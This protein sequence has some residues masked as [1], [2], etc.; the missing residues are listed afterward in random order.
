MNDS[1]EQIKSIWNSHSV[2]NESTFDFESLQN[3]INQLRKKNRK[4]ILTWY[5]IVIIF[6]ITVIGYVVYTDE[7]N[8]IYKSFAEFLLLFTAFYLFTNSWKNIRNQRKEYLLSNVDFLT[9]L[10]GSE[11]KKIFKQTL[12]NC[13]CI[14]LLLTAIFLYFLPILIL[15]SWLL[16]L[17]IAILIICLLLIWLVLKPKYEEK[18]K[19]KHDEFSTHISSIL[20]KIKL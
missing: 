7:L 11:M 8:S 17:S 12:M 10:Q 9:N 18:E 4:R 6:S 1:F 20:N 15:S 19:M 14:T 16:I 5:V 2:D 3:E 13:V